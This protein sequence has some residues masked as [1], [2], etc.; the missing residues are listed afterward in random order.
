M[1]SVFDLLMAHYTLP[2][3]QQQQPGRLSVRP[4]SAALWKDPQVGS[5]NAFAMLKFIAVCVVHIV[6]PLS[7]M[8]A[9]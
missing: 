3:Q 8:M 7:C 4:Y 5:C 6:L 9:A 1:L 2:S